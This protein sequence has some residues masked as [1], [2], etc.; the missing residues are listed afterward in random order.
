LTPINGQFG[1]PEPAGQQAAELDRAKW[2]ES[3][4]PDLSV[5]IRPPDVLPPR[6]IELHRA[7]ARYIAAA[8]YVL[9]EDGADLLILDTAQDHY[10]ARCTAVHRQWAEELVAL[11]NRIGCA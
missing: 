2:I 8:R 4:L 6:V 9:V 11:A 1:S 10:F 7:A 5:P 3:H